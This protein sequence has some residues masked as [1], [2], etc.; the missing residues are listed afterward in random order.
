MNIDLPKVYGHISISVVNAH[1]FLFERWDI[2]K[3]GQDVHKSSDIV[4]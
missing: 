3:G 2:D 1:N 4:N